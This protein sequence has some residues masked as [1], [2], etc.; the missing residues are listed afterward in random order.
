MS[1]WENDVSSHMVAASDIEIYVCICIE[2]CI[3]TNVYVF[4]DYTHMYMCTYTHHG[5]YAT[6]WCG[7]IWHQVLWWQKQHLMS[8]FA[9]INLPWSNLIA[10]RARLLYAVGGRATAS[11]SSN[12]TLALLTVEGMFRNLEALGSACNSGA[13]AAHAR[14]ARKQSR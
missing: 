7:V 14:T 11:R 2:T 13:S 10:V 9:G 6:L 1:S 12:H 4:T 5:W 8:R 3:N